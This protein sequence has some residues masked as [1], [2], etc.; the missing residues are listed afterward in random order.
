MTHAIA[1]RPIRAALAAGILLAALAA[2]P[3]PAAEDAVRRGAVP[4]GIADLPHA[5]DANQTETAKD[6][7]LNFLHTKVRWDEPTEGDYA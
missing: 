3:A 2:A 7:G 4:V 1:T 6:L 5:G